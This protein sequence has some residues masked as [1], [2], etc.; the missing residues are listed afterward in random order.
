MM[1]FSS[2]CPNVNIHLGV[3]GRVVLPRPYT[4]TY[5]HFVIIYYDQNLINDQ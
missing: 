1:C 2:V 4:F 3:C 5:T